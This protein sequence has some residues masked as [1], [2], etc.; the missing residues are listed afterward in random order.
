MGSLIVWP[1]AVALAVACAERRWHFGGYLPALLP[2]I[3]F[4]ANYL[5]LV[6]LR[7]SSSAAQPEVISS[8]VYPGIITLLLIFITIAAVNALNI[9]LSLDYLMQRGEPAVVEE[10]FRQFEVGWWDLEIPNIAPFVSAV[11][12]LY[13]LLFGVGASVAGAAHMIAATARGVAEPGAALKLLADALLILL[14]WWLAGWYQAA[15]KVLKRRW[16]PHT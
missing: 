15:F 16:W 9:I 2:G 11:P 1:L 8:L 14:A 5:L 7:T 13:A 10:V 3:W 12:R 6:W 4:M